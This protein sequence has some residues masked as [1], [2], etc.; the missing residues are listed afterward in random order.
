MYVRELTVIEGYFDRLGYAA[1]CV[2]EATRY[3]IVFYRFRSRAGVGVIESTGRA[4]HV[5]CVFN[6]DR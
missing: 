5:E 2:A 6:P 1:N 3:S 4:R